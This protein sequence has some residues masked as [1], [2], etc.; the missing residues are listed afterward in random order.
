MKRETNYWDIDAR[1]KFASMVKWP[2]CWLRGHRWTVD[3]S[4]GPIGSTFFDCDRCGSACKVVGE[5]A[6]TTWESKTQDWIMNGLSTLFLGSV[7]AF[8][9]MTMYFIA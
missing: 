1:G 7:L 9:L 8:V 6:P 3:V 4:Y 5:V 2:A